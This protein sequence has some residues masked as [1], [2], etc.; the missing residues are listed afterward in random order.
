MHIRDW[1]TSHRHN[2]AVLRA[3][4]LERAFDH[5]QEEG[6]PIDP[7][8]IDYLLH[9]DLPAAFQTAWETAFKG[10][11]EAAW[12]SLNRFAEG[13]SKRFLVTVYSGK[14]D[15]QVMVITDVPDEQAALRKAAEIWSDDT[16]ETWV[17]ARLQ[18][19]D[20]ESDLL[21]PE[22]YNEQEIRNTIESEGGPARFFEM[23]IAPL[24]YNQN[25]PEAVIW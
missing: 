5:A 13:K 14:Y 25:H 3:W 9:A 24:R 12:E 17:H 23:A 2:Q 1:L 21:L 22:G 6:T 11:E 19:S 20:G 18:H 7:L 10:N 8:V 16:R 4:L 15:G